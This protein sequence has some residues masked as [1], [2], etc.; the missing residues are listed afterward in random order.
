MFNPLSNVTTYLGED[1]AP[2]DATQT[3]WSF[4]HKDNFFGNSSDYL[5]TYW[6][7][8]SGELKWITVSNTK[9][10]VEIKSGL[11]AAS[12]TDADFL[13]TGCNP[14]NTFEYDV[15]GGKR[16]KNRP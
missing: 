4:L 9:I 1:K 8:Q 10:I 16:P 5:Y 15:L 12:F 6:D 13:L 2:W 7:K 11:E 3:Y 14:F